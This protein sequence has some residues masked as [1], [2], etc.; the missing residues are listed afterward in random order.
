MRWEPELLR[1]KTI[2]RGRK[3]S[4]FE[5]ERLDDR[6]KISGLETRASIQRGISEPNSMRRG[7][8]SHGTLRAKD[9]LFSLPHIYLNEAQVTRDVLCP[10][11]M[12]CSTRERTGLFSRKG[13]AEIGKQK[14]LERQGSDQ[15]TRDMQPDT[16][17]KF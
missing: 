12:W 5:L 2:R 17:P 3:M 10:G 13:G 1:P 16:K 8:V 6:L 14:N 9:T 11:S 4:A 15:R 7:A